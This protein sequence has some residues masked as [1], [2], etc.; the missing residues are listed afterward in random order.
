[1]ECLDSVK[2][3]NFRNLEHIIVD[4]GSKDGTISIVEGYVKSAGYP[5]R[6]IHDSAMGIS[7]AMNRGIKECRGEYICHLHSDDLFADTHVLTTVKNISARNHPRLIVGDCSSF[8]K[9]RGYIDR[10]LPVSKISL[11]FLKY[12]TFSYLLLTN[13]FP[14]PS[15]YV[16]KDIFKE[17][18]LFD[19]ELKAVMDY[20]YWLRITSKIRP[21]ITARVFS[22]YRFHQ[23]TYSEKN[24]ELVAK[25]VEYVRTVYRKS[26]PY[27]SKLADLIYNF[28]SKYQV[29]L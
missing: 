22:K 20:E 16:R 25:E 5:V 12:F 11:F 3:Q 8:D 2:S 21:Y 17:F 24:K 23:E 27:Y 10:T 6:L 28:S 29:E 1:M 14:H 9:S 13:K 26:H 7:P 18:G 4:G 15:V 19:E